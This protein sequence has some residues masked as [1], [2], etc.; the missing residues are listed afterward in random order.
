MRRP[1]RDYLYDPK[2]Q[3]E[4]KLAEQRSSTAAIPQLQLRQL[5][6]HYGAMAARDKKETTDFVN[7]YELKND[8]LKGAA[9]GKIL[10]LGSVG[11]TM[12]GNKEAA[13]DRMLQKRRN[14]FIMKS[15][16]QN[17]TPEGLELMWNMLPK[18]RDM[19]RGTSWYQR[20]FNETPGWDGQE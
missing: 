14:E 15:Y 7:R 12:V 17:A 13:E 8:A 1:V 19:L 11:L 3:E 9:I 10:G 20:T 16:A 18:Q 4:L 6:Q 5:Y 2:M